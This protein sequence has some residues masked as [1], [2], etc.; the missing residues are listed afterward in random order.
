MVVLWSLEPRRRLHFLLAACD[1]TDSVAAW[2]RVP[3]SHIECVAGI[4]SASPCLRL[5][6]AAPHTLARLHSLA[7]ICPILT[8]SL[9][10]HRVL[11]VQILQSRSTMAFSAM[12]MS[13]QMPA[14]AGL[15]SRLRYRYAEL[16][17]F[18]LLAMAAHVTSRLC[19]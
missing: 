6:I 19:A 7:T 13:A 10:R 14:V 17:S 16:I 15:D 3:H 1:L 9:G 4:F 11:A 5:S 12:P 18:L 8:H 2:C